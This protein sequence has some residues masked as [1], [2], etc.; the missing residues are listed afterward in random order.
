[1][2]F[3]V[4]LSRPVKLVGCMRGECFGMRQTLSTHYD[5]SGM[6]YLADI[7]EVLTPQALIASEGCFEL[8][9]KTPLSRQSWCTGRVV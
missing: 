4:T 6:C 5:T 2:L 1:M 3:L 9:V 7:I 8:H